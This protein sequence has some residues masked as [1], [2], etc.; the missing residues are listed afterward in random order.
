MFTNQL[1]L[2]IWAPIV[3]GLLV[4]ATGGDQRA[5]LARWVAVAGALIGFLL[6]LPLFTGFDNLNGGMQFEK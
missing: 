3:A 1:S 5:T 4:L 2:V 6:S